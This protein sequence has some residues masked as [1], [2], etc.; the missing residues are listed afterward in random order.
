MCFIR[1]HSRLREKESRENV[2]TSLERTFSWE[3]L[4]EEHLSRSL[5]RDG[6]CKS[7]VAA[8]CWAVKDQQQRNQLL[9]RKASKR[10]YD[11]EKV[12]QVVRL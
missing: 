3:M 6:K 7:P 11:G 10:E 4:G 12:R 9:Q 2:R 5:Q 8:T 1:T